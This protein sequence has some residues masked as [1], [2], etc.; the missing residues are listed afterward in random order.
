[1]SPAAAHSML[2]KWVEAGRIPADSVARL[3][4]LA[5]HAPAE[6]SRAIQATATPPAST[7]TTAPTSTLTP[8]EKT[9]ARR[10]GVTDAAFLASKK[11][12][13]R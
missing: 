2:S 3:E 4:W 8:L 13:S 9:I 1:M 6:L 5:E 11:G 12:G 10:M 7:T